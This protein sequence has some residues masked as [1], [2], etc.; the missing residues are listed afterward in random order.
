MER[1][2]KT[3][4]DLERLMWNDLPQEIF[5]LPDEE[6]REKLLEIFPM[7]WENLDPS[8]KQEFNDIAGRV[9]EKRKMDFVSGL[10]NQIHMEKVADLSHILDF[11][12]HQ[13][14]KLR[15]HDPLGR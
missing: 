3:I 5:D 9:F 2:I 6:R 1:Q 7:W 12:S 10:I 13:R 11:T 15:E 14:K 8:I 4:D